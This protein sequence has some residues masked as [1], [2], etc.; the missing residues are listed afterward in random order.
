M[1]HWFCLDSNRKRQEMDRNGHLHLHGVMFRRHGWD[2]NVPLL[3]VF[4]CTVSSETLLFSLESDEKLMN[5]QKEL[6]RQYGRRMQG[7]LYPNDTVLCRCRGIN[8]DRLDLRDATHLS[9]VG[10]TTRLA[11]Q[12]L[13]YSHARL[14]NLVSESAALGNKTT[15]PHH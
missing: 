8:L 2:G 6:V 4:A 11:S 10:C 9:A 3:S 14:R 15:E 13:R 7:A 5:K 12:E 1:Q